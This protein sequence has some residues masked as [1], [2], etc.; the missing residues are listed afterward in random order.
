MS[1]KKPDFSK[2]TVVPTDKF[3]TQR[4]QIQLGQAIN[5]AHT[6][7]MAN[8]NS[9]HDIDDNELE[10]RILELWD[11]IRRA[12]NNALVHKYE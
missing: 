1:F 6:E 4:E 2:I 3:L 7:S 8:L 10:H 11:I 9:S 12:E 5:L